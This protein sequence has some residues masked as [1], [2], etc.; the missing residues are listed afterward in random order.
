MA[1]EKEKAA[2]GGH[3]SLMARYITPEMFDRYKNEESGGLGKWTIARA[4]NTGAM[5]PR[6]YMGIH[7]GDPE[8]YDK[9]IDIYKVSSP[10]QTPVSISVLM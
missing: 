4:I 1:V 3:C 6:A 10:L 9:F 5:F 2:S 8:S 7:A